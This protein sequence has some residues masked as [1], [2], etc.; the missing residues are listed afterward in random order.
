MPALVKSKVGSL[1]G[2]SDDECTRRCPLPSKKR[3]NFSRISEPV[4]IVLYC[5]EGVCKTRKHGGTEEAEEF[6]I[7][8]SA[9][10]PSGYRKTAPRMDTDGTDFLN[11][12]LPLVPPFL[13]VSR[14]LL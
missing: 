8:S 1:A 3:R 14:V 7:G 4:G 10:G 12:Y 9:I 5:I 13:C 11:R 2:T 6:R